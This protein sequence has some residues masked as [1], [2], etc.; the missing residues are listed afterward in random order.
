MATR[1]R[2]LSPHL[3]VYRWQIQMATSIVHRATGVVLALG[4][5]LIAASLIA[6]AFGPAAWTCIST[7]AGT[8]YGKV[9][10]FA[11]TWAFAFHLLNGIRHLFQDAG[12]GYAIAA[13]VRNGWL[14][15]I[16]S[17]LLTALVWYA[18]HAKGG[19]A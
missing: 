16:G 18:V 19:L 14:A 10:L 5:L 9:F 7:C 13:F 12:K 17:L 8:W 3:Q 15:V 1:P 4:A 11:W 6:L 2:P